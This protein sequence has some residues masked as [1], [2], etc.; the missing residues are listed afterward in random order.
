[1]K[2]T[3]KDKSPHVHQREKIDFPLNIKEREDLTDRQKELIELIINKSTKIVLVAG[4]AG[5]SKSFSAMLAGLKL[6]ESTA[7]SDI[8]YVR[9]IIESASKSIGSLPGELE[10]K[11]HPFL[12]PLYDKLEELLP[13]SIVDKLVKDER[14]TGV[15]INFLRGASFNAKFIFADEV[16]NMQFSEIKTLLS[17]QGKYSKMI[18]A[19]D[20]MQSDINGKSGFRPVFNLFNN[21]RSREEGI[22]CFEFTKEDIVRSGVVK[23]IIEMIEE[24]EA[25]NQKKNVTQVPNPISGVLEDWAPKRPN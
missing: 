22:H 8:I 20:F 18:L 14:I 24:Y 21:E 7:V 1:M 25:S 13:K 5:T 4:P 6:L 23:F 2:P 15:P 17:R 16:Q 9:S 19:G 12:M 11:M 3:K 10:I